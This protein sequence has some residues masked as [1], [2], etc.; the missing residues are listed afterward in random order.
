MELFENL[1]IRVRVLIKKET[2]IAVIK[3]MIGSDSIFILPGGGVEPGE[4]LIEAACRE[5][6]EETG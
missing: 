1:S 6:K 5:V 2:Q 3:Q 4:T